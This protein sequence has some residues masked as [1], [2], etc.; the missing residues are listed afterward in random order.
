MGTIV[1]RIKRHYISRK[2]RMESQQ[3]GGGGEDGTGVMRQMSYYIPRKRG[4]EV[5]PPTPPLVLLSLRPQNHHNH[6]PPQA[7]QRHLREAGHDLYDLLI[8]SRKAHF[9]SFTIEGLT[10]ESHFGS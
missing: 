1:G 9:G 2:E 7:G 6:L 8:G 5:H 4:E 3:A 10:S